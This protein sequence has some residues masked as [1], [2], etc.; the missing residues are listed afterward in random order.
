MT[1]FDTRYV[2]DIFIIYNGTIRQIESFKNYINK[3]NKK[4]QFTSEIESDN[5][6]NFLDIKIKK[7]NDKL[8]FSVYRKPTTTDT[9]IHNDLHH[10][11]NQKLAAFN[12]LIHKALS[13]PMDIE[14]FNN[15]INIIKQIAKNNGYNIRLINQVIENMKTKI[16]I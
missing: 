5:S 7:N 13:I 10:P 11:K 12:S 14:D 2:D 6:I 4:I 3:L 15:E 1:H 8:K 16:I 9:V